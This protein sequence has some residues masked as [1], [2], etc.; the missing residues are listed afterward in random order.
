MLSNLFVDRIEHATLYREHHVQAAVIRER[1]IPAVLCYALPRE[2]QGGHAVLDTAADVVDVLRRVQQRRVVT[3]DPSV[4]HE[5]TTVGLVD[6]TK[7][8]IGLRLNVYKAREIILIN[9]IY[10]SYKT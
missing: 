4:H 2:P 5:S 9:I 1:E 10:K 8:G 3:A 6:P 7:H